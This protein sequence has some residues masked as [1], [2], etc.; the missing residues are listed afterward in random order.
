MASPAVASSVEHRSAR[1]NTAQLRYFVGRFGLHALAI[2]LS[3]VLMGPFIW[4]ILSSLK[5]DTEIKQLPPVLWPSRFVWFNYV[6]VWTTKLFA[7]WT[8]NTMIVSLSAT[9]GTVLSAA[10]AGYAFARFRFP[11][12]NMLF[13]LTIATM[14]LPETVLLIPRFILYYQ[15]GW[16]N[17]YWPLIVLHLPVPPVLP[18]DSDRPGRGGQDRRRRPAV[19][20]LPDRPAAVAAGAG[21]VRD[22]RVRRPL[23]LVHLPAAGAERPGEVHGLDRPALV[24]D[25]PERGR[26]A[27]RP[28]VAGRVDHDDGPDYPAVLLRAAVLRAGRGHVGDQGVA[29]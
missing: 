5:P 18:D 8:L 6:E 21:D 27:D 25:Q 2:A 12:R 24:L 17:S 20:P 3:A 7:T 14:L 4:A 13:G 15:L 29:A 16:L 26:A 10:L 9:L 28:P 23:G 19:D 1:N 22:H 11:G